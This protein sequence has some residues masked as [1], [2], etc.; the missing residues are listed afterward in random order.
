MGYKGK[1]REKKLSKQSA[2][3]WN[4]SE[5]KPTESFFLYRKSEKNN[6]KEEAYENQYGDALLQ[7]PFFNLASCGRS[8]FAG[9]YCVKYHNKM[10]PSGNLWK[11]MY[12]TEGEGV[13][14]LEG[15]EY[16]IRKGDIIEPRSAN[17]Q[18]SV[19]APEELEWYFFDFTGNAA[20]SF[21]LTPEL[22][23]YT[24]VIFSAPDS[25]SLL[26]HFEELLLLGKENPI[27]ASFT[28]SKII[29]S[30][31]L[32]VW[33]LKKHAS[34]D[35]RYKLYSILEPLTFKKYDL[36]ALADSAG[37]SRRTLNRFFLKNMGMTPVEYIR[38]QKINYAAYALRTTNI[39]VSEL[40]RICA[41]SSQSYFTKDFRRLMGMSPTEY[42]MNQSGN[43]PLPEQE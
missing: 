4:I 19:N 6:W 13:F 42:K 15:K 23:G 30:F 18:L 2:A 41:Y 14:L 25:E 38:I 31:L 10:V 11:F 12:V 28:A 33:R 27:D 43:A 35:I 9:P 29:Y 37:M 8:T 36:D 3:K 1:H 17:Y 26:V 16:R 20:E 7:A 39:S 21:F 40:A 32:D 34:K 22:T 5:R 24:P